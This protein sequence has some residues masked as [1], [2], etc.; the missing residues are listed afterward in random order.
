M[1]NTNRIS[2]LINELRRKS[3]EL[4]IIVPGPNFRYLV[5]SYIETFERF[6]ALMV[7]PG[8]GAHAMIL[9]KLDE[10]KAKAVGL[11]YIVYGDEEGPLNAVRVFINNN[12]GT[13]RKIGLEGRATLNYLWILRRAIGE[14]S[15]YS[16]DDLLASMRM[17]K[18]EDEL[19]NIERAVRA[20][21]GGI[22]AARE[23]IRPGMTE[24]DVASVVSDAISSAGAEP[25]D[26]LVQ[27]GP[28]SAIPHWMPSRRRIEVGDVVVIDVT[29]TYNDYYGDLTRTL[30]IGEPPGDFW[31]VYELVRRLMTR[32]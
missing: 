3:I 25:R 13:V 24:L 6:G 2:G 23:A 5:G 4:A 10:G 21:E 32:Q 27:S 1:P 11:P 7:C 17:S 14:F 18:D 19:R 22:K 28:N 16:I 26:V 30:V 15:D 29:A 20:I 31:R 8:N 9:P 12:C